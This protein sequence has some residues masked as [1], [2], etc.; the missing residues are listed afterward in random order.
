MIDNPNHGSGASPPAERSQVHH[1]S[2]LE[3]CPLLWTKRPAKPCPAPTWNTTSAARSA[4]DC[5]E[6]KEKDP[7]RRVNP[8][9]T[10]RHSGPY[11]CRQPHPTGIR[12]AGRRA[13]FA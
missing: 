13:A 5:S 7:A 4:R 8:R 1:V 9:R 12:R 6:D 3:D 10:N 11:S 2:L